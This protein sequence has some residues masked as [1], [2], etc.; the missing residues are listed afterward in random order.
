MLS[1]ALEQCLELEHNTMSGKAY[2]PGLVAS[3][4]KDYRPL[5]VA[6]LETGETDPGAIARACYEQ[7]N[8]RPATGTQHGPELVSCPTCTGEGTVILG[9]EHDYA[10]EQCPK[11]RGQRKVPKSELYTHTPREPAHE[12]VEPPSVT[13][14]TP[15]PP[16]PAR[17]LARRLRAV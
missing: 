10:R 12:P 14:G 11:C 16:D 5:V 6:M 17:A 15:V 3:W 9:R 2:G 8:G 4:R 1:K 7:R 13:V